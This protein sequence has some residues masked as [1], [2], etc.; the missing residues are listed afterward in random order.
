TTILKISVLPSRLK[1]VLAGTGAAAE[2][3]SLRWA[4]IARGVGI[5][6]AALLPE[7]KNDSS[8]AQVARAA[9]R[10][11]AACTR[12]EGHA[13]IPWCPTEWKPSLKIWGAERSDLP[14]MRKLKAVFDAH[15]ILSPGRFVGGL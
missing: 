6:Y 15:G 12:L 13:T 3:D 11:Q 14:Q 2:S 4:A 9:D 8:R 5:V 10:I 1:E 7:S